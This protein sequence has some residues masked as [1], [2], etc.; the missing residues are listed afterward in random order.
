MKWLIT[1]FLPALFFLAL[2]QTSSAQAQAGTIRGTVT[3][4]DTAPRTVV[5]LPRIGIAVVYYVRGVPSGVQIV[6]PNGRVIPFR[7]LS[8]SVRPV[9]SKTT[10]INRARNIRMKLVVKTKPRAEGRQ[11]NRRV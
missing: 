8:Q 4:F 3:D 6:R 7:I 2:P 5:P 1:L 10:L 9:I 11:K